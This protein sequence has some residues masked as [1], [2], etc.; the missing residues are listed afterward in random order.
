MLC[1]S[2][3]EHRDMQRL[4]KFNSGSC[5]SRSS[6][7][8]DSGVTDD[9]RISAVSVVVEHEST[10]SKSGMQRCVSSRSRFRWCCRSMLS[11]PLVLPKA[12]MTSL[13]MLF[14]VAVV[15]FVSHWT[16]PFSSAALRSHLDL[17]GSSLIRTRI[18]ATRSQATAIASS[19]SSSTRV[20]TLESGRKVSTTPI[21]RQ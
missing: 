20:K 9:S 2:S 16:S 11:L 5:R 10:D 1:T 15:V 21:V 18:D 19:S 17:S 6:S 4:G 14:F 12:P 13:L 7:S 8:W 3:L